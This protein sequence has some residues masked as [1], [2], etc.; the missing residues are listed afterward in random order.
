M[1]V[2]ADNVYATST[3]CPHTSVSPILPS[4]LHMIHVAWPHLKLPG[5]PRCPDQIPMPLPTT[6]PIPSRAGIPILLL[7]QPSLRHPPP[8]S[9]TSKQRSTI[10]VHKKSPLLV[11]T[12]PQITRALAHSHPF[13]L[14]LNK[15]VGLISWTTD[16]PWESYL[17]VAA[18][19][20]VTIYGGYVLRYTG[21][22]IFVTFL[23]LGMY[24]R[25]Y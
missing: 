11:A 20:A 25:R 12:P 23:I 14:P 13:L 3:A 21:P 6:P 22:L 15:F 16:D 10:I 24:S 19:W 9:A 17:L 1:G 5:F 4:P 8:D 2:V 18:F 7:M